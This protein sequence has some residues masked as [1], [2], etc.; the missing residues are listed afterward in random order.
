MKPFHAFVFLILL[1]S[2][3]CAKEDDTRPYVMFESDVFTYRINNELD[4]AGL[5]CAEKFPEI[6]KSGNDSVLGFVYE[7]I[8]YLAIEAARYDLAEYKLDAAMNC[9]IEA[10]K[11]N[12][13]ARLLELRDQVIELRGS[14]G[15]V[16]D[17]L[18]EL[19]LPTLELSIGSNG[20]EKDEE[21]LVYL[22]MINAVISDPNVEEA[23]VAYKNLLQ[24]TY[25]SKNVTYYCQA[26]L[27]LTKLYWDNMLIDSIISVAGDIR[28]FQARRIVKAEDAENCNIIL[29]IGDLMEGKRAN[30][31]GITPEVRHYLI[32]N[33]FSDSTLF[34]LLTAGALNFSED[35]RSASVEGVMRLSKLLDKEVTTHD[36]S[37]KLALDKF[38]LAELA[39]NYTE[40]S[41]NRS[42]SR[43]SLIVLLTIVGIGSAIAFALFA[44]WRSR[45]MVNETNARLRIQTMERELVEQEVEILST[46]KRVQ[47]AERK[48][49]A[50]DMHDGITNTLTGLSMFAGNMVDKGDKH[51]ANWSQSWKLV[52][53]NLKQVVQELRSYTHALDE[54]SFLPMGFENALDEF[55][56][57]YQKG[58]NISVTRDG[59]G[60][61]RNLTQSVQ[62][63]LFRALQE[64]INNAI[65]HAG[66]S[67][68]A[69]KL[70]D[71]RE[72]LAF[73]FINDRRQLMT[74]D[75]TGIGG[76]SILLRWHAI[77]AYDIT[78]MSDNHIFEMFAKIPTE[79]N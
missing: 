24:L 51:I 65:K 54:K 9:Y 23:Y 48:K 55:V 50:I 19:L 78:E 57:I 2:W 62:Y 70:T 74:S 29:W 6:V 41:R 15:G 13:A 33:F 32:N 42:R 49:I 43:R 27:M 10:G 67:S 46:T 40:T 39:H 53:T 52:Q 76:Q 7:T 20:Y 45:T 5:L 26:G 37:Y 12:Y 59:M 21:Y 11:N 36:L 73:E 25:Y 60:L 38:E 72:Y 4:S 1:L 17:S 79:V 77:N 35:K 22:D 28:A 75:K 47:S 14:F 16:R 61:S 8:G 34:T 31:S 56:G 58:L 66:A 63:Q 64:L 30:I 3:G 18:R 69:I 68:I 44:R 71:H